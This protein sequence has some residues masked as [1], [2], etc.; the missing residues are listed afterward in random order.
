MNTAYDVIIVGAGVSG[1]YLG[2]LLAKKGLRVLILDRDKKTKKD[3]GIV[4]SRIDSMVKL[5]KGDVLSRIRK[6]RFV[7]PSGKSFFL[8]SEK[9]FA[10]LLDR[11]AFEKGL[12]KSATKAGA[13]IRYRECTYFRI[14]NNHVEA[15]AGETYTAKMIIGCDG[16]GSMVRRSLGIA[17]PR[18]FSACLNQGKFR[19]RADEIEVHLNKFFSPHFFAWSIPRTCETGTIT[20]KS[21]EEYMN[22]YNERVGFAARKAHYHPIPIGFTKS[23]HDRALLVG[24]SCGQVKPVSGGG[25]IYSMICANHAA[26]TIGMAFDNQR[27][28]AR[29]LGSYEKAWR[30]ELGRE[31]ML[32]LAARRIYRRMN[33]QDIENFFDSFGE[34]I[35]AVGDFDYDRLSSLAAKMPRLKMLKYLLAYIPLMFEWSHD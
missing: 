24:D 6:I 35:E 31:Q 10:Y 15:E 34:R 2:G 12:R 8:R 14:Y 21:T 18:I 22:Y 30:K 29:F 3:S 26:N 25:I 17:G 1:S 16:A 20:R 13:R 27:F 33:N 32:Q 7:S 19:G 28:D 9:P 4:S 5:R 23:Y 11:D